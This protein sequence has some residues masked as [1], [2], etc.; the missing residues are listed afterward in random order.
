[1]G[2]ASLAT[3]AR[4]VLSSPH[5]REAHH[6]RY[7]G[8]IILVTGGSRGIGRDIVTAFADAGGRVFTCGRTPPE[9]PIPAEFMA[10][11]VRDADAVTAMID[12]IGAQAGRIDVVINNAGGAPQTD[13]AT[14]SPRFSERI[15]ALNLLAPIHVARAAHRWIP[16]G[17]SIINIASVSAVRPSPGT[18]VYA[19]AKAGL[20]GLTRSLAQEW[21]PAIRVNAIIAGLIETET[22]DFTYGSAAARHALAAS[23]PAKRLG[24][25]QDIANAA[26]FLA[27][28]LAA[29]VNGEAL[30]VDGGGERPPFL[31]IVAA[32]AGA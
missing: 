14:A 24:T 26:L 2:G 27:S 19:A 15:I 16:P 8:K 32:H 12:A 23:L 11:D 25:G 3:P 7:D 4:V 30:T 31:G 28:D 17:G 1:L 22:A 29:Y 5:N 20:L 9:T 6:M 13:A 18:A 10:C 21:A